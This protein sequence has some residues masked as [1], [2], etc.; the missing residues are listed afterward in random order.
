V[1]PPVRITPAEEPRAVDRVED[2]D[3]IGFTEPTEF[4]A[5]ERILRMCR[6]QRL[7]QQALHSPVGFRHRYAVGLQGCGNARREVGER[8]FRR[9]VRGVEREL[10]LINAVHP[11]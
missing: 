7:P 2:P 10:Q 8:E 1:Y 9:Q 3:P 11:N 5:E 6:R 4:L